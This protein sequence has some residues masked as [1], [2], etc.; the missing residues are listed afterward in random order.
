MEEITINPL[1]SERRSEVTKED[2]RDAQL[3]SRRDYKRHTDR[4]KISAAL[5]RAHNIYFMALIA[6]KFL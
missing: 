1:L 5:G 4:L 3:G 6:E 2:N